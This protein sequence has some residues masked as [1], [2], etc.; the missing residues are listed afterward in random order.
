MIKTLQHNLVRLRNKRGYSQKALAEK[1][2]MSRTAYTNIET[3]HTSPGFDVLANLAEA[4]QATTE[5]FFQEVA[6]NNGIRFRSTAKLKARNSIIADTREWLS[7][8]N[9]LERQLGTQKKDSLECL[10]QAARN[11]DV[12]EAAHRVRVEL[13]LDVED[14]NCIRHEPI[15]NIYGL[16]EDRIGIKVL[17]REVSSPNFF[18]LSVSP[19]ADGPAIVVN[20]WDKIT[21]ERWIFTAAHEFAHLV[22][23]T[24][25]Y[26]LN[27][28]KETEKE[29]KEANVFASHFLMPQDLFVDEWNKTEGLGL[30]ERVQKTKRLFKVSHRTILYR[31][32]TECGYSRDLWDLYVEEYQEEHNRLLENFE[33]ADPPL[34][35]QDFGTHVDRKKAQEKANLQPDDFSGGRFEGLVLEAVEKEVL[36]KREAASILKIKGEKLENRLKIRTSEMSFN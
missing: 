9:N 23:H 21:V 29:E 13:C 30:V 24:D 5:D 6:L 18:G 20:T 12:R 33:E 28:E 16:M 19:E 22:L 25:T 34:S 10:K 2:G 35:W 11:K 3:G 26:N 15:R 36:T 31:L 32:T 8:Y 7:L 1:A 27:E 4:L 17:A 14:S